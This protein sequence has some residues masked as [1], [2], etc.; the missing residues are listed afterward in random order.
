MTTSTNAN[1]KYFK[2]RLLKT[3]IVNKV[4]RIDIFNYK[5]SA[6]LRQ[7]I[8]NYQQHRFKDDEH[9]P[10]ISYQYYGTTSLWWIIS[11][12]NGITHPLEIDPGTIIRIP[13]LQEVNDYISEV[14]SNTGNI[15]KL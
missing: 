9:L 6:G 1:V 5:F 12:F 2:S 13:N 11:R 15:I 3:Q 7:S 10:N 14:R 4:L 8:K